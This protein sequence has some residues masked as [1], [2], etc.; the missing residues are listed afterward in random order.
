MRIR[1]YLRAYSP[2]I[3]HVPTIYIVRVLLTLTLTFYIA[4]MHTFSIS[5]SIVIQ[6]NATM[7]KY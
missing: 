6:C 2:S 7:L 4:H 1:T 5:L 3:P